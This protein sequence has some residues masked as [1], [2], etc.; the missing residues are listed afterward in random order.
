MCIR[1]RVS[2]EPYYTVLKTLDSNE[3]ELGLVIPYTKSN[4][5]SLNSYLVGTYVGGGNRLVLYKLISD[6]TLPGIQ[7]MKDV[8]KRQCF[9]RTRNSNVICF[10]KKWYSRSSKY[11]CCI[12]KNDFE[13]LAEKR[14]K[15]MI[16]KLHYL[17]LIM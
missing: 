8:Y 1:D 5:Q 12:K 9:Y 16:L 13:K 11:E 4:K 15:E 14:N 6:T 7:Q 17:C 3:E 10:I 2:S